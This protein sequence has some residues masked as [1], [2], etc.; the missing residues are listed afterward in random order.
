M[1]RVLATK[2]GEVEVHMPTVVLSKG[3]SFDG[4]AEGANVTISVGV[5]PARH[6]IA[7]LAFRVEGTKAA[8]FV[9]V[10]GASSVSPILAAIRIEGVDTQRFPS[11]IPK[12]FIKD[13]WVQL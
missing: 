12:R 5:R 7:G 3:F 10:D 6:S 13:S 8:F 11:T 4:C 9:V 2:P 1:T